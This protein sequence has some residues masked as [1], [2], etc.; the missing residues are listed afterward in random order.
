MRLG[1]GQ[2][3]ILAAGILAVSACAESDKGLGSPQGS[4]MG[5]APGSGA[6]SSGGAGAGLGTLPNTGA[7]A[8]TMNGAAPGSGAAEG[9]GATPGA[10]G[11][12]SGAAPGTGSDPAPASGSTP[13]GGAAPASGGT[14][15]SSGTTPTEPSGGTAPSGGGT[16]E[17]TGGSDPESTGGEETTPEDYGGYIE[18]GPWA[19]YAWTAAVPEGE[20][21]IDPENYEDV[22]DFPLCAQ[23]TV[24]AQEDYG[25]VA[26]V[27]LNVNQGPE[28]E[29]PSTWTPTGEGVYIDLS[30]PGGSTVRVQIQGPNGADDE[31]DRWCAEVTETGG[32]L[33]PWGNFN[34]TC[35][36]D[37]GAWYDMQPLEAI[38]A[39]VP[40]DDTDPVDYDLC[41]NNLGL[42]GPGSTNPEGGTG[43]T[44][45]SGG[46]SGGGTD[47]GGGTSGGGGVVLNGSGTLTERYDWKYV[48]RD[49]RQ[50]CVQNNVWGDNGQQTVEYR[51]TT[52]KVVSA[53]GQGN[54]SG[55]PMSYPSVFIGSNN[56]RT[57]SDSNLPIQVS[58]IQSVETSWTWASNGAPGDYN[59]SYDVWFSTSASGDAGSPSG[60]YLMVWLHDPGGAQP[61]GS[62]V[63]NVTIDGVNYSIWY[64][65][66]GGVGVVSYLRGST[67]SMTFD[68]N[69]FIEDAIERGYVQSSWYLSNVFAGFEIWSGGAGLETT[70]FYVIVK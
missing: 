48:Q 59:A 2:A 52:F 53:S 38:L 5:A 50:Y 44:A 58:A 34:T 11:T 18:V 35:W 8:A 21:T 57:T 15:G 3:S 4:G 65:N 6:A 37:A 23:G 56:E 7:T 64:G 12:S 47:S 54:T 27:G 13:G 61:V 67:N 39:L 29:D 17:E 16:A 26:M 66:N 24:A 25:G 41:V 51:G 68:L 70:D 30:N 42:D 43:G 36:D 9:V 60:G 69:T 20:T 63:G 40:G 33:I 10:G 28:D 14:G 22:T 32:Q 1:L 31:N 55:A 45:G 19:G 62:E 49:G 46:T